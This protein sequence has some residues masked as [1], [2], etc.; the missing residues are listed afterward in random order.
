MKVG[1][2]LRSSHKNFINEVDN[3]NWSILG[4]SRNASNVSSFPVDQ[5]STKIC[6]KLFIKTLKFEMAMSEIAIIIILIFHHLNS[7][8]HWCIF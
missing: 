6:I 7:K 4:S 1:I 8:V 3:V 2:I 5:I